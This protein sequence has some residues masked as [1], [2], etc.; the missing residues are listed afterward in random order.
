MSKIVSLV[1]AAVLTIAAAGFWLKS[2]VS[3]IR[4]S[5]AVRTG[6]GPVAG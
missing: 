6:E 1:F 5:R 2:S 4:G 3:E